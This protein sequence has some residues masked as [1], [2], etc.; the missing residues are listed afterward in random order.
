ME[1]LIAILFFIL[2]TIIGSFLNV[3]ILR[4]GTGLSPQKGR[5][6]CF[7]CGKTLEWHELIPV[8]SFIAQKGRCSKCKSR[9]SIQY[10]L[11]ETITG[12]LFVGI[13]FRQFSDLQIFNFQFSIFN[14][15]LIY[16]FLNS[17]LLI[18]IFCIL[19]VITG[20]DWRHKIIPD[21]FV[22]SFALLSLIH[23][24][25]FVFSPGT[26]TIHYSLFTNHYLDLLAGP[27]LA[28]PF[29]LLWLFSGGRW[30]GL[31][32]AKLALGIGWLLGLPLGLSSI[33]LAFWVGAVASLLII[34]LSKIS[35]YKAIHSFCL[36]LG[37]KNPTMKSEMPFAPFLILAAVITFFWQIDVVG[38]ANFLRI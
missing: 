2:G 37:V 8:L 25:F 12:I 18:L 32:D 5:S 10:P 31:G 33:I 15:F 36:S 27:I 11:V 3:V 19:I 34:A 38:L 22:Y 1:I 20:Y 17:I 4:Y 28:L 23:L 21:G 29:F 13:F 14:Q 16:N 7:S 24:V 35:K 30:I 26:F 6:K 9:I